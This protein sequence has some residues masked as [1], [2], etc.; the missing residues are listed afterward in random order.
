MISDE[1]A[2]EALE[3]LTEDARRERELD[4]DWQAVEGRLFERLAERPSPGEARRPPSRLP[5]VLAAAAVTL[6]AALIS[7][8]A[9]R[10]GATPQGG[11]T[12]VA[13]SPALP[14]V[15]Q[16][17]GPVDGNALAAGAV[18]TA[19]NDPVVVEHRGH[20]T[21]TLEPKSVAHVVSLGDVVTVALDRGVLSAHVVKS[22][23][24]ESFV[25]LVD[26]TRIAVHGTAFRVE[27]LAGSVRVR[28]TE[29]VVA[30]GP[31]G[32][33]GFPLVAPG[34]A[35]V[36]LDGVRTGG[37]SVV[38]GTAGSPEVVEAPAA[39]PPA[40]V[41][42]ELA[43]SSPAP[44]EPPHAA[45]AHDAAAL[46][47]GADGSVQRVIATVQRCFSEHTS[48]GGDLKVTVLTSMTLRVAPNGR[49]GEAVFTPPLAPS[50]RLCVDASV[51]SLAFPSSAEG[52]AVERTLEL[53]H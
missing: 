41:P 12:T 37:A 32:G 48:S 30:V 36:T 25:V 13:T 39:P 45:R 50:V 7:V 29:G 40:T 6:A 26:R 19:E 35:T 21:W 28:V 17:S 43:S 34:S 4:V 46:P 16:A 52:F 49:V 47:R 1:R 24:P 5:W 9:L 14:A 10:H 44:K 15:E 27:R 42:P 33:K 3:R 31:V 38:P 23:R 18:V 22:P 11:T 20:A 2:K 53:E 8:T 51:G